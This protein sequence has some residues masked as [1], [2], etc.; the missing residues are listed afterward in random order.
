MKFL[1]NAIN[2]AGVGHITRMVAIG[3][4]LRKK[5]PKAQILF[6]TSS[7]AASITWREGFPSVKI[8][9]WVS[10]EK[11]MIALDDYIYLSSSLIASTVSSFRPD[12]LIAD[13]FPLGEGGQL[14]SVFS[15]VARKVLILDIF[16]HLSE[17]KKYRSSVAKYD[18]VLFPFHKGSVELPF[19][20]PVSKAWI[21]PIVY[22]G[23]EDALPREDPCDTATTC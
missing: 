2:G 12:V 17:D 23:R 10:M 22:R 1:L 4:A 11:G 14:A 16:P 15:S 5:F 3:R 8:P 21:G 20:P 18:L 7:E 9:S 6:I 19:S 13:S